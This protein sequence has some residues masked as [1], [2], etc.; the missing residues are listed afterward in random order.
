MR[1]TQPC[2]CNSSHLSK[3][4]TDQHSSRKQILLVWLNL[5]DL[6]LI[7]CSVASSSLWIRLP[8]PI[9]FKPLPPRSVLFRL[10]NFLTI[11]FAH[12]RSQLGSRILYCHQFLSMN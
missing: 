9:K 4:R 7:P 8:L 11:C 12:Y 1:L 6:P 3:E 10:V 2:C 5:A